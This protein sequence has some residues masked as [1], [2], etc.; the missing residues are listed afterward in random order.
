MCSFSAVALGPALSVTLTVA[1]MQTKPKHSVPNTAAE[2]IKWNLRPILHNQCSTFLTFALLG[3]QTYLK[4]DEMEMKATNISV[5][6][7]AKQLVVM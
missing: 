4:L 5:K 1:N 7:R 2:R 6:A 3:V